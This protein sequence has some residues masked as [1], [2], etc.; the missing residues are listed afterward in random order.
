MKNINL[1]INSDKNGKCYQQSF[2]KTMCTN[3]LTVL[4]A[5]SESL[6]GGW[7]NTNTVEANTLM[8]A[9]LGE[10]YDF[11]ETHQGKLCVSVSC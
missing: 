4:T 2:I 3:L 7:R 1:K 10:N 5:K 6:F 8:I 9:K 11:K